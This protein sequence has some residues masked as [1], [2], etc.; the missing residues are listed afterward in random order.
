M[1]NQIVGFQEWSLPNLLVASAAAAVGRRVWVGTEQGAILVSSQ[2][3]CVS[4]V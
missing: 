3:K 2:G 4:I 1:C